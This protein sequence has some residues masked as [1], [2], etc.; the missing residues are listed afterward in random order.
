MVH[1]LQPSDWPPNVLL[2][3]MPDVFA[4]LKNS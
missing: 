4:V 3:F 1:F 2:T